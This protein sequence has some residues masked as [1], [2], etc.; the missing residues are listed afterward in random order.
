MYEEAEEYFKEQKL[1]E[2][3]ADFRAEFIISLDS[4]ISDLTWEIKHAYLQGAYSQKKKSE[5][6]LTK[7]KEHIKR[8]LDCLQQDTNDPQTNY[9]VVQYMTQAEQFLNYEE[10][11]E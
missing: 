7:A 10:K 5:E 3:L 4:L 8:L 9:Y 2:G 1:T 6:M 11:S